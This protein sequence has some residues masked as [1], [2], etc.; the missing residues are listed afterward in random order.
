MESLI[1]KLSKIVLSQ[2]NDT[3][4]LKLRDVEK[5]TEVLLTKSVGCGTEEVTVIIAESINGLILE[6]EHLPD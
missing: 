2:A 5:S 4:L 3:W 1:Y 6:S